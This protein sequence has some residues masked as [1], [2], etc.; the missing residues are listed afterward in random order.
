VGT[1]PFSEEKGREGSEREGLRGEE[2]EE[3]VIWM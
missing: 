2:G 3:A 1:L